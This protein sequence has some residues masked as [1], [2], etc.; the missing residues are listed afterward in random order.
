[1]V[2]GYKD[3][4]FIFQSALMM[5]SLF[6]ETNYHVYASQSKSSDLDLQSLMARNQYFNI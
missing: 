1:M 2:M 6:A 3:E 4:E 5:M